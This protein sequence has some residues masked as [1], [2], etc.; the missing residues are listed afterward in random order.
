M[1]NVAERVSMKQAQF[2]TKRPYSY[3]FYKL[4]SVIGYKQFNIGDIS[5]HACRKYNSL[6]RKRKP[7]YMFN[8]IDQT[9][10]GTTSLTT[11]AKR[12][13][14]HLLSGKAFAILRIT[15]NIHQTVHTHLLNRHLSCTYNCVPV[16]IYVYFST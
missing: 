4:I 11:Y 9:L 16:C 8:K 3:K 5:E 10:Q 13:T 7:T 15:E 14:S 6:T 12:I 1:M 2:A